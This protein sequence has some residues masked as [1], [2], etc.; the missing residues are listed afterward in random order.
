MMSRTEIFG[1]AIVLLL[2]VSVT[3]AF[4]ATYQYDTAGRL[5]SVTH[6]DGSS[7]TYT[8]DAA[9]NI[10][11]QQTIAVMVGAEQA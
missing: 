6:D 5:I 2:A 9:G 10:T 4:A 8:Y 1:I 3:Q 7:I 11:Q